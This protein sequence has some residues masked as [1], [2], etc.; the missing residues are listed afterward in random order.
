MGIKMR[1][2]AN[3]KVLILGFSLSGIIAVGLFKM[4]G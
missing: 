4:F 3:K 2:W 1:D